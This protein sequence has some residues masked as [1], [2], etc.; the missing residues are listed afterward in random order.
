MEALSE[1]TY[2]FHPE[3]EEKTK[4]TLR[5]TVKIADLPSLALEVCKWRGVDERKLCSG[6]RKRQLVKSHRIFS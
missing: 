1:M 5:L 2:D 3:A 4:E 6:S